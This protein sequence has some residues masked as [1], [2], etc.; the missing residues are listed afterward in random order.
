MKNTTTNY[1][2]NAAKKEIIITK[3]FEKAANTIGSKEYSDLVTL[4]RDFPEFRITVKEIKKKANKKT[5]SGLTMEEM[6]RFVKTRSNKEIDLF[7]KVIAIAEHK[8]GSY[9]VTKKWFLNHYKDE[10]AKELEVLSIEK[11]LDQFENEVNEETELALV[12]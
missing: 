1:T 2:I 8:K 6:R 11:E 7:E 9:A 4:M 5:Y 12:S 3:K 10:Y